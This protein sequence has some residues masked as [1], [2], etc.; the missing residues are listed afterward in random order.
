[1][2]ALAATEEISF[3]REKGIRTPTYTVIPS[4]SEPDSFDQS[5]TWQA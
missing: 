1:M 2:R 4:D 3:I 5:S